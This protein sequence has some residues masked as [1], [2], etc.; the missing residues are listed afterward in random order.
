M[1]SDSYNIEQKE[2]TEKL[3][4]LKEEIENLKMTAT[5]VDRFI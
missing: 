4:K 3:P 1:L 5:N 2:I